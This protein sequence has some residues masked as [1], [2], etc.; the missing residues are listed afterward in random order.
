VGEHQVSR[1]AVFLDRDGVL[2]YPVVHKGRPYPPATASEFKLYPDVAQGAARLSNAGFLLV[3]VTNQPDVGRGTQSKATVEEIHRKLQEAIPQIDSIEVCYHAG[4]GFGESCDCR[5]PKPGM[6]IRAAR[7]SGIDLKA[8]YLVGD[9]WRDIDC[10]RS[11]GCKSIL[12]DREYAEMLRAKPDFTVASFT[13]AVDVV[14][15]DVRPALHSIQD[16]TG[17]LLT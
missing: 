9:R 3:V 8:S 7:E 14:L 15:S 11:A 1:R 16:E 13:E 5:K 6:L 2:N 4:D 12:I 17:E 10:A